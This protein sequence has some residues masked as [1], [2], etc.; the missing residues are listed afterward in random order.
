MITVAIRMTTGKH[1]SDPT[2]GMR[3]YN[4]TMIRR[5]AQNAEYTPEPD[6][7]AYLIRMGADVQEVK[8]KMED[9]KAGQSYLTPINATKYMLKMLSAILISQ[10]FR[11]EN[12]I[13]KDSEKIENIGNIENMENVGNIEIVKQCEINRT[14]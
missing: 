5:F 2:S 13:T 6:T 1:I 4:R 7:I 14:A 11:K 8:V 12:K 9:R 10:W 3:L